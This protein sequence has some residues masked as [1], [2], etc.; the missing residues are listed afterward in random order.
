MYRYFVLLIAVAFSCQFSFAQKLNEELENYLKTKT[1]EKK[2]NQNV[3]IITKTDTIITSTNDTI[4]KIVPVDTIKVETPEEIKAKEDSIETSF[5]DSLENKRSRLILLATTVDTSAINKM[6]WEATDRSHQ[7]NWEQPEEFW[8]SEQAITDA[9]KYTQKHVLDSAYKV[10][11]WHPFWMG[12]AYKN[13][14]YS[15]LTH[16]AYFSYIVDPNTGKYKSIHNWRTTS[17]IDS[18]HNNNC[19]ALLTIS[20]FGKNNNI[21][22]LSNKRNQHKVLIENLITLL[23]ERDADGVNVDF[24]QIPANMRDEF[25]NFIIDL[26]R[27]LRIADSSYTVTLTVPAKDFRNVYDLHSLEPYVD[28][29]VI[30]GYLYYGEFSKVAGPISPLTSGELWWDLT[31]E[32]TLIE[33]KAT[34][35]DQSKIIMGLP[36]YGAEWQTKDL[37]F[38][39]EAKSF[40]GYLT[41]REIKNRFGGIKPYI[42]IHSKSMYHPYR[43]KTGKYYQ[44]WY[45]DTASLGLKYDLIK[46][47]GLGGVGIWALG[48]D[49]GYTELWELLANKFAYS[50]AQVDSL[51]EAQE[52]KKEG[53]GFKKLFKFIKKFLKNPM[54]VLKSPGPLLKLLGGMF[55]FGV[56]GL[57]LVMKM[58]KKMK[59]T[60]L[61]G[62]KGGLIGLI[63]AMMLIITLALKFIELNELLFLF[64]GLLL[65]AFILFILTYKYIIRDRDLP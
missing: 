35:I 63:I 58:A 28:L 52:D 56:V 42:D 5:K 51:L 27:S 55:G 41:Y 24:E 21:T 1:I 7:A 65:G 6:G 20:N 50:N 13:Y 39:S 32:K 15:L 16:I 64:I 30:M 46:T 3:K 19:K 11:G 22:F 60:L 31:V 36:Y 29:F 10:F 14:N 25:T 48:Y 34:G 33:Y 17:L 53:K 54:K 62:A 38:P 44:L 49:N 23:R 8:Q 2:T 4:L 9:N 57:L 26:S 47:E 61:V 59:K 37:T 18:A 45:E 40:A 43:G 12:N